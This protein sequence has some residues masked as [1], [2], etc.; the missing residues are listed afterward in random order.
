M[1]RFQRSQLAPGGGAGR[2]F[3]IYHHNMS[4]NVER[5][6]KRP[7]HLLKMPRPL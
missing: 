7:T 3:K 5:Y 6:R 2:D 1:E 4:K